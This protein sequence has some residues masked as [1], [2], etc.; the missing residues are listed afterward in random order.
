MTKASAP[1]ARRGLARTSR[2]G[3]LQTGAARPR[4]GPGST[5][6]SMTSA[7]AVQMSQRIDPAQIRNAAGTGNGSHGRTMSASS[8]T[9]ASDAPARARAATA[10]PAT[11][12]IAMANGESGRSPMRAPSRP[13]TASVLCD[14]QAATAASERGRGQTKTGHVE[15]WTI[16][17]TNRRAARRQNG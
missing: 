6:A 11:T 16:L 12:A 9:G 7:T 5:V 2:R 1:A 8:H 3:T 14:S 4:D 10:A 13:A 15:C 17:Q